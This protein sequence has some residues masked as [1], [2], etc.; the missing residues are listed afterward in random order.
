VIARNIA[1]NH[2]WFDLSFSSGFYPRFR[3][4]LPF[5]FWPAAAAIKLLGEWAVNPVYA[6]LTLA[7]VI[8]A[9]RTARRIAGEWAGVAAVLSLG[10][11]E[12]IWHYGGRPLLE[13]PLFLLTTLSAGAALG[14][15]WTVAAGFGALATLVKGPF[16]LLP[17]ACA[18]LTRAR[19]PR[20]TIAVV[21]AMIPLAL[22]LIV[23]PGGGWRESYLHGQLLASASGT[24][25]DGISLWWFPF[26]VIAGRFWPGLPFVL[27]APFRA[28]WDA[29][30]R[31]LL[32]TCAAMA[33]LLCVPSRKWG[34]HTY[35][36][37]PLLGALAGCAAAS[38]L[39]KVRE[40]WLAAAAS[41]TAA[42]ACIFLASGLGRHLMRPPCPFSA[43]LAAPLD[44]LPAGAPIL[45]VAPA[46]DVAAIAELAAER[47]L[48]PQPANLLPE[49]S[50]IRHAVAR[51]TVS[52]SAAWVEIARA[53]GWVFLQQGRN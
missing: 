33:L 34:N 45:V 5:G 26:A 17:L 50:S 49:S 43:L 38:L 40:T 32:C 15:E 36:A 21:A 2:R 44:A 6:L 46:L 7:A 4:H 20:A 48:D 3:E 30:L 25:G 19:D 14:G 47:D 35:V 42:L 1:R 12:I 11:C 10:T 23:D 41:G 29:R 27:L 31:P 13:P 18:A 53:G 52:R 22:F 39:A 9:G 37:F 51:E 16:G 24:R 8:A 28:R